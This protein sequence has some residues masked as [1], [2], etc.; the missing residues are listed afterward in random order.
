M[1]K[2]ILIAFIAF[3]TN[4]KAQDEK[5]FNKG[6]SVI[7]LGVGIGSA[8][9]YNGTIGVTPIYNASY[10]NGVVKVGPGI[11]GVGVS[12]NYLGFAV[13]YA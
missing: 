10:E 5:C 7:N 6:T 12:V 9:N 8:I 13:S 1:K 4:A 11:F 2:I 3:V